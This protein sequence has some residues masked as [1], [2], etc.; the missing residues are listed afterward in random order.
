M[1][2]GDGFKQVPFGFDKNEVNSYISDLRKKMSANEAEMR[3][4][5]EKTRAAEKLAAEADER[6]KAAV[7]E[8]NRKAEELTAQLDEER[9]TTKRQLIEIRNLK[10]RIDA[11]KKKMTDM[12]K[13]GRGVSEEATRAFNEVVEKANEEASG[14]IENARKQADEIIAAARRNSAQISENSDAF[15]KLLRE[16]L[17]TMNSGYNAMNAAAAELLGT[18]PAEAVV[19]PEAPVYTH[20]AAPA[21]EAAVPAEVPETAP[22]AEPEPAEEVPAAEPEPAEEIP[23]AEPEPQPEPEP[24]AVPEPADDGV[25]SL[26]ITEEEGAPAVFDGEWAG[27]DMAQA[28]AEAE[29]SMK[30]DSADIPLMNPDSGDDPFGGLFNMEDEHTDMTDLD[31]DKPAEHEEN[32]DEIKPLDVSEHA[33]AAFNNDFTKDLLS[34]TLSS[35]SLDAADAD[36]DILE[37]VKA[38]EKAFAVQPNDVSDIDMDEGA[39][40]PQSS[41]SEEDELMRALREAEEA[42]NSVKESADSDEAEQE[43]APAAEDPWADLQKQ[44][45]A[46][47]SANGAGSAITYDEPEPQQEEEEAA[48]PSADDSSIWDFGSATGSGSSDDDDMSSDFGGFGGF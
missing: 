24:E 23:A 41:E 35:N 29:K 12:L 14:I 32:I 9:E 47:E 16:Q 2:A 28:V 45:E 25:Q 38:A 46:M 6:I 17:E 43:E 33:D 11:E 37:A 42:L 30:Q 40:E 39:E 48:P 13:S 7:D 18:Q 21:V 34:Q 44:L 26:P 36:S 8:G 3:K 20:A 27:N 5:D 1:A 22:A 31:L 19:I 10:D 4:N 15:L